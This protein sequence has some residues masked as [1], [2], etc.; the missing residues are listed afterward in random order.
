[1]EG[2]QGAKGDVISS[3]IDWDERRLEDIPGL[4]DEADLTQIA[5][6]ASNVASIISGTS[7]RWASNSNHAQ[8]AP[9][10]T[11]GSGPGRTVSMA[12]LSRGRSLGPLSELIMGFMND[13]KA[14]SPSRKPEDEKARL[15]GTL[16]TLRQG[17]PPRIPDH[18]SLSIKD[19]VERTTEGYTVR[20]P[21][22]LVLT[23]KPRRE[24][25]TK[26]RGSGKAKKPN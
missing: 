12:P 1:M 19:T 13:P 6:A 18:L 21:R 15:T 16:T 2:F 25:G 22:R 23:K 20:N 3:R 26:A 7:S 10:R 9:M 17:S 4:P 24:A 11:W 5:K 8:T 14:E